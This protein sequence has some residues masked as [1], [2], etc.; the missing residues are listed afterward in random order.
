MCGFQTNAY[1]GTNRQLKLF[2]ENQYD[3]RET[4]KNSWFNAADRDQ[5]ND[6]QAVVIGPMCSNSLE[7]NYNGIHASISG[8]IRAY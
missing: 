1:V 6:T 3:N 4:I 2:A 5:P 8:L 7:G